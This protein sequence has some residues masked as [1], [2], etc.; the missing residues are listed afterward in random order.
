MR[1]DNKKNKK[2]NEILKLID[3]SDI[4]SI[5]NVI[6]GIIKIINDPRS[7]AMDLKEIIQIDPPL[8]AKVL[9]LANSAYYSPRNKISE[10]TQAIIWVGFDAIKELAMSQKVCEIF[11]KDESIDGY[12][13][14]A[15]WKHSLAVALLSKMIYRREFCER[16]ESIYVAGLLHEIGLIA[17]DQFFSEELKLVLGK[18]KDEKKNLIT[19]ENEI[20]G[21]DHAEVGK[22]IIDLWQIPQDIGVAIAAHHNPVSATQE[23]SKISYTLY[24]ADYFCQRKGVGYGDAPF[25]ESA[26]YN[27]Y[28]NKLNIEPQSLELLMEDVQLEIAKMEDQ[29][30]F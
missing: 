4:S 8:T 27:R 1:E 10:I 5:K 24:V 25:E 3:E 23:F 7:T 6:S 2:I 15:L 11:N 20:S 21:Y 14:G 17:K 29:G 16:G 26:S 18:S 19:A 22:A 28:R 30:F 13:R 9:K 12:S